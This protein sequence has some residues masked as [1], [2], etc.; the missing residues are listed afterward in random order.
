[1]DQMIVE[2][3]SFKNPYQSLSVELKEEY[4]MS[5]IEVKALIRKMQEFIEKE[6]IGKR[7]NNQ[8]VR[9]VVALGEPAGK[10]IKDC[11]LVS[12]NLTMEFYGEEKILR[13]KGLKYLKELKVHQ[14]AFESYEQ[15]GL[16]SHEDIQDIL[17]I[18]KS[19]IKRIVKKY[20]E[21]D[22]MIPTRGQIEDIGPGIT[23]K[24]RVIE[25]IIKGYLYSDIMIMTAHT[26]ASIENY[27]KKFVKIAYF[28]RE[29]KN[30][31]KIRLITGYSEALIKSFIELYKN[32]KKNYPELVDN[33]LKRYE[34]YI[35]FEEK[36]IGKY[37]DKYM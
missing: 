14:L 6:T 30:E 20:K 25:L 12:V 11:K 18:S 7:K 29:G 16:L 5:P 22:I 24:E 34:K 28:H 36:K 21:N 13:E 9:F 2:R 10:K 26:E 32:N 19:T 23:H 17:G 37:N 27:E 4:G 15:G 1:M 3:L 8:I 35:E 33:M 31:L